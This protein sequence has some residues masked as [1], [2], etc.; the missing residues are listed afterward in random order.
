ME[1]VNQNPWVGVPWPEIVKRYDEVY[2]RW[3]AGEPV[4]P[5]VDC[6]VDDLMPVMIKGLSPEL[7]AIWDESNRVWELGD[8]EECLELSKR[9]FDGAGFSRVCRIRAEMGAT[10]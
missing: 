10:D 3:R 2:T 9:V 5:P 1:D 4:T 7:Q 6:P 8:E